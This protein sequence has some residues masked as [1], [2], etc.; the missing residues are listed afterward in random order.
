M[1]MKGEQ[2][3]VYC[4]EEYDTTRRSQ[5]YYP[6]FGN[7]NQRNEY[8]SE[9]EKMQKAR[10]KYYRA[11]MDVSGID[12]E[13]QNIL[14]ECETMKTSDIKQESGEILP[15][16]TG[17]DIPEF[18][19][20]RGKIGQPGDGA[21]FLLCASSGIGK[22]TLMVKLYEQ[23][24]KSNKNI[25]PILISP[26]CN[27]GLF[28]QF[29]KKVI[30]INKMNKETIQLIKNLRKIQNFAAKGGPSK[31]HF[32][33]MIDDIPQINYSAIIN[34]CFL[35]MRNQNFNSLVS[36]QYSRCVSKMGRSSVG[37]ILAGYQNT[38]ESTLS[39]LESFLGPELRKLTG[40]TNKDELA[41]KYMDLVK[42][43]DY[44]T[45]FHIQ[46]RYRK[47]QRFTLEI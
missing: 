46:P 14:D 45:F 17:R 29:D 15:L 5:K 19:G 38:S 6:I 2:V 34:D 42:D 27:I 36:V 28:D 20:A 18:K 37:N 44:H 33:L 23:Y 11:N 7:V 21:T 10:N 41:E 13:I 22:S 24:F 30:R 4:C 47:V 31:Y 26:S 40:I 1:E 16:L 39:L 12:L 43:N 9:L 8:R 25:I 35:T 3:R 32:L